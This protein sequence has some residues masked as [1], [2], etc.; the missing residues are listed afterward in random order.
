MQIPSLQTVASQI[1][2]LNEAILKNAANLQ[3]LESGFSILLQN[4]GFSDETSFLD[5]R[6]ESEKF[7]ELKSL[8]ESLKETGI[9]LMPGFWKSRG[10]RVQ[11]SKRT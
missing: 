3:P 2:D 5:A 10:K 1:K 9:R 6:L 4:A 7:E 11:N 8:G